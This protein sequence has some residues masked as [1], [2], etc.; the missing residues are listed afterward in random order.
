MKDSF[1]C[2]SFSYINLQSL[3]EQLIDFE[4]LFISTGNLSAI[5]LPSRTFKY[6][7]FL[8]LFCLC[9]FWNDMILDIFYLVLQLVWQIQLYH[10]LRYQIFFWEFQVILQQNF[11]S[12]LN[13]YGQNYENKYQWWFEQWMDLMDF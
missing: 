9:W 2:V 13:C 8:L 4:R 12:N 7:P 1:M 5:S 11:V 10:F 3:N 6:F